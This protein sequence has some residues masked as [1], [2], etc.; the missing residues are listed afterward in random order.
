MDEAFIGGVRKGTRGRGAAGKRLVLV[1]AEVRGSAVGRTRLQVIQDATAVT[2]LGEIQ[3]LV[4]SGSNDVT[5]GLSSYRGLSAIGCNRSVPRPTAEIG[6]NLVSKAYRVISWLKRWLLGTHQGGV[7]HV[8]L[9]SY[10]DAFVFRFNRRTAK[11]C[12]LLFRYLLE[13]AVIR[14]PVKRSHL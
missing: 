4:E 3:M 7:A 10:L 6:S 2:L 11:S 9:Q 1:C 5:G 12:G 13:Q 14:G 8:R